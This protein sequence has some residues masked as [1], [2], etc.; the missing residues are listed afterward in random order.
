MKHRDNHNTTEVKKDFNWPELNDDDEH[1][2]IKKS[3]GSEGYKRIMPW[4]VKNMVPA[5]SVGLV[6]GRSQSFKT[7][8]LVD[9]CCRVA[10][11]LDY[12]GNPTKQ[13]LVFFIAAEG[14]QGIPKRIRA[15][16]LMNKK[17]VGTNMVV[18]SHT[19]FP[20]SV[21]QRNA[22]VA[23]IRAECERQN[24]YASLVIFD[25]MSQCANGASENDA[26]EV[27]KYL[28]QC[29][30]IATLVR[31][32][33]INVHHTK[34]E[35][36]DFRGSSTIE[37]NLDFMIAIKRNVNSKDNLTTVRLHKMKEAS[38]RFRW[39]LGLNEVD[40]DATDEDGNLVSTL[41]VESNKIIYLNNESRDR[42]KKSVTQCEKDA[43]WILELLKSGSDVLSLR[44][45]KES[46]ITKFGKVKNV[47]VR[48]DRAK[49]NLLGR[50][51]IATERNDE[52]VVICLRAQKS[53]KTAA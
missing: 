48:I 11:G 51:L 13:G 16:E 27:S 39:D 18:I 35:S 20:T 53:T 42:Q 14:S 5:T 46:I 22:L 24:K 3:Y 47:G 10:T 6:Y 43:E 44:Q 40:I 1:F 30:N 7:F 34:K 2:K 26:G 38:T 45:I 41:C 29:R 31:C 37:G 4:L 33:V 17:E 15:W 52:G 9:K 19:V 50:G 21:N 23:E 36:D 32:T 49:N 28:N 12:G 25:T 8:F